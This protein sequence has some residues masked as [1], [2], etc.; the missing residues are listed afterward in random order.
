MASELK[1]AVSKEDVF[2]LLDIRV[3]RVITVET[4]PDARKPSY[5][6]TVDFG[7]YGIKRSVA[8]LTSHSVEELT[9]KQVF[10]VLNFPPCEIGSIVSEFLCL[11]VQVPG[12]ESGGATI[13]TPLIEAKLGSKMF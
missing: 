8:R 9:G 6:L 7:K 5:L 11:G 10:G 4:A 2:D 1:P 12:A 13:V 3:G